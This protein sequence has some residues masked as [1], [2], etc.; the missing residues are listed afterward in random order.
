MNIQNM[1]NAWCVTSALQSHAQD[2]ETGMYGETSGYE[3][4]NAI[5]LT[6]SDEVT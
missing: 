1:E 6:S 5:N 2:W 3:N 4:L